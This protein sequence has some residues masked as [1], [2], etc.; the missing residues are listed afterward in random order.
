M[1]EKSIP[2][3]FR[4]Q[5]AKL[6]S[7]PTGYGKRNRPW[8]PVTWAQMGDRGPLA[9]AAQQPAGRQQPLGT[10]GTAGVDAA[11]RDPDLGA[12]PV[13][14]AIGE[15]GAGVVEH[16]GAVHGC[17]EASRR[18]GVVGADGGGVGAAGGGGHRGWRVKAAAGLQPERMAGGS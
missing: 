9:A 3:I 6:Q 2:A 4:E 10:H 5:T 12:Q 16:A 17:Q 8:A 11:R 1:P 7:R 13:A 14:V 15:A 18:V